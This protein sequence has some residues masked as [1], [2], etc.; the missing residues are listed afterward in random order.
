MQGTRTCK[1]Y[2]HLCRISLQHGKTAARAASHSRNLL[3]IAPLI[4]YFRNYDDF[5]K[6]LWDVPNLLLQK[7]PADKFT[8]TAKV[9]FT[10]SPKYS[11]ERAGLVCMGLDYAGLILENTENGLTLS[12]TSC[13]KADKGK[14]ETVHAEVAATAG[15]DLYLRISFDKDARCTFSYSNDGKKFTAIGEPFQ[16]REG[17]WIGAKTGFF[18]TRPAIE[19][20][21]GGWLDIDWFHITK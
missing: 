15:A 1:K 12:Q 3:K 17:K 16:A 10:P 18:C 13:R 9:K 4:A 19:T 8:V 5:C 14:P 21:D 11:G 20:N 6:N 7:T 2:L